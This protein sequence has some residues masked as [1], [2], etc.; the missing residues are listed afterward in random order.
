MG[1]VESKTSYLLMLPSDSLYFY[2]IRQLYLVKKRTAM[3][4][5]EFNTET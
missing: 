5:I 4:L 1:R 3:P 2:L